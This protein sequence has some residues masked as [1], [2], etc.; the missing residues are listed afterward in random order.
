MSMCGDQRVLNTCMGV[1]G[2]NLCDHGVQG[3]FSKHR[4]GA[5]KFG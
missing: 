2:S 3:D 1:G 5:W 4:D